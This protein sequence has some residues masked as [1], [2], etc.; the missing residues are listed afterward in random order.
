MSASPPAPKAKQGPPAGNAST[1]WARRGRR[2]TAVTQ[3][4]VALAA[5]II[6]SSAVFQHPVQDAQFADAARTAFIVAASALL[7]AFLSLFPAGRA[8]IEWSAALAIAAPIGFWL[9]L[10]PGVFRGF[11]FLP[12]ADIPP[13]AGAWTVYG[14]STALFVGTALQDLLTMRGQPKP[15]KEH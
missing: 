3:G 4:V 6:S 1:D 12:F 13:G 15:E 14:T 8:R 9:F 11:L 10:H 5:L 2:A 7:R